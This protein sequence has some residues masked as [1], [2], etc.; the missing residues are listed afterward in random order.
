MHESK[1]PRGV[2]LQKGMKV[3]FEEIVDGSGRSSAS[4]LEITSSSISTTKTDPVHHPTEETIDMPCFS[5]SQPFASLLLNKI[6]D[7]ET[8]NNPMF[9]NMKPDTS[10]LLHCGKRDWHDLEAPVLELKKAGYSSSE[11]A[12]HSSLPPGFRKG[13]IIGILKLGRTWL[14]TERERRGENMQKRV[15]ARTENI[16]KYCTIIEDAKWMKKPFTTAKGK[17]GIF[18]VKIPKSYLE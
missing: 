14:S 15:V 10:I 2:H 12:K 18:N 17:P 6:K 5:M 8:R 4:I 11:I 3:K 16:G 9:E 13:N 7:I 1:I